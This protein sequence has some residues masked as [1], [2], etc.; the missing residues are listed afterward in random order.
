M[1][2]GAGLFIVVV[3]VAIFGFYQGRQW[4]TERR[5]WQQRKRDDKD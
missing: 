3:I 5:M 1:D 4:W 2:L